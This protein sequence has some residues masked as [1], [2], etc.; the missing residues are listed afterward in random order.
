MHFD[1]YTACGILGAGVFVVVY[2]CNLRGWLVSSDWR[3]P[4]ANMAGALLILVSLFEE[5]NLPSVMI[6]V[7]WTIIS[8]YGVVR[9]LRAARKQGNRTGHHAA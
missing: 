5:W 1:P 9:N 8:L 2:F 6:E 3:Y 7:F 4:A